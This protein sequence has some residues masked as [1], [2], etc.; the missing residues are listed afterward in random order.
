MKYPKIHTIWKRDAQKKYAIMEGEFSKQEFD[1]VRTWEVTEKIDGTNIR[2]FLSWEK[3]VEKATIRFGGRTDRAQIPT[4]LYSYLQDTFTEE[5][6]KP[7]FEGRDDS[8]MILF[9]EG[10]WPKIQKGG[11]LYREDVSF[12]LFDVCVGHWWFERDGVEDIA[13]TL[14]I[15]TVPIIGLMTIT[16]IENYVRDEPRSIVAKQDKPMEGIVARPSPLMLFR[17]GNPIMI[18][19]KIEDYKHL[20]RMEKIQ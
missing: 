2:V 11:G 12:I 10:Y 16:E 5:K 9:G 15:S 6:C 19:L 18:K 7:L 3:E 17:D 8:E 20:E 14:G 4:F 1:N 13:Q